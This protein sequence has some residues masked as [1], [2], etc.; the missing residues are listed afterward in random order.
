MVTQI[1]PM[2]PEQ[3]EKPVLDAHG[4]RQEL[5]MDANAINTSV[6]LVQNQ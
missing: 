2:H 5:R 1:C 3:Q 6:V 4:H